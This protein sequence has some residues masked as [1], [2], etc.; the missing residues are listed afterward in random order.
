MPRRPEGEKVRAPRLVAL[1][2]R[3]VRAEVPPGA[4]VLPGE[5]AAVVVKVA[6]PGAPEQ[7]AGSLE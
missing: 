3:P 7:E 6:W 1:R 4:E 5:E 2:W